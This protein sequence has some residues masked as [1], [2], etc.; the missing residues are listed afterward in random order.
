MA[1]TKGVL[2]VVGA[3]VIQFAIGLYFSSGN[4]GIYLTSYLRQ[5]NQSTATLSDS[6]WFLYFVGFSALLLPF[7]GWLDTK[8]GCRGVCIIGGILQ[9]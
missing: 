4:T 2:A 7:G 8:I 6:V 5:L 3:S 9:R 1:R